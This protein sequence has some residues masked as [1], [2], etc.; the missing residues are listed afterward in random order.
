MWFVY[1]YTDLIPGGM[2]VIFFGLCAYYW[3]DKYNLLR[4]SSLT[5]N[6]GADLSHKVSDLIDW[7]LF[8]RF[9]G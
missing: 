4:R 8:W 3:V 2:F 1:L 9:F 7:T 5:Y 6:I